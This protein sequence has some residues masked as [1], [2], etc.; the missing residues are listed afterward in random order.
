ML[1]FYKEELLKTRVCVNYQTGKTNKDF[2]CINIRWQIQFQVGLIDYRS[3][4]N[5]DSSQRLDWFGACQNNWLNANK[6][7]IMSFQD[8]VNNLVQPSRQM[9]KH[10]S[11]ADWIFWDKAINFQIMKP[12]LYWK[13]WMWW[14]LSESIMEPQ[15]AYC[16]KMVWRHK[17]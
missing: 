5:N 1:R 12:S 14:E 2:V 6:L 17:M 13:M 3:I 4:N 16:L 11:T 7:C 8:L 9:S 15:Q 10:F